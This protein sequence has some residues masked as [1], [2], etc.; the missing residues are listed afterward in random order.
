MRISD[1][2][3][4]V[5]SSDLEDAIEPIGL[6]AEAR[7]RIF[8]TLGRVEQEM[9]ILAEPRSEPADLPHQPLVSLYPAAH[10]LRQEHVRLLGQIDEDRPAL[11]NRDRRAAVCRGRVDNGREVRKSCVTGTPVSVRV[12]ISGRHTIQTKNSKQLIV[13]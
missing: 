7:H 2:S 8:E 10:I 9:A 6:L 5:C 12:S 4:D 1:W 13:T 11:E 3:S